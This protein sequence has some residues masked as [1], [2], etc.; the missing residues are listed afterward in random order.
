[1]TDTQAGEELRHGR[2]R[3]RRALLRVGIGAA[4][5][6][7]LLTLVASALAICM[8]V[9]FLFPPTPYANQERVRGLIERRSDID[10]L[11]AWAVH[12]IQDKNA[13][14]PTSGLLYEGDGKPIIRLPKFVRDLKPEYMSIDRRDAKAGHVDFTWGGGLGHY[15]VMI[16][17]PTFHTHSIRLSDCHT[18]VR[19]WRPGV[20]LFDGS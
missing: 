15:G 14:V 10:K 2:S 20:Y 9:F 8:C 12:L 17:P 6:Y 7:G 11:Q 16:G 1:M 3:I 13:K 19:R 4:I 5:A 18:N